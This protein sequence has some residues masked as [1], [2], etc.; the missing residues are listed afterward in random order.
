[1]KHQNIGNWLK[2]FRHNLKVDQEVERPLNIYCDNQST[3]MFANNNRSLKKSKH[4]DIKYMVVKEQVQN[5]QLS[6]EHIDTNSMVTDPLIKG[7]PA[8]IF[9]DILRIW[10]S[11]HMTICNFSGSLVY[12]VCL[13]CNGHVV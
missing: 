8:S 9:R 7:V 4:I 2:K 10:V 11:N 6:I 5:G 13:L 12:F 1:M 3:V